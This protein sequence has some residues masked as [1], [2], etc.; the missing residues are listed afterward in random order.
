MDLLCDSTTDGPDTYDDFLHRP[1][2]MVIKHVLLR[3]SS[4]PAL[5]HIYGLN[6]LKSLRLFDS[7]TVKLNRLP[8][9]ITHLHLSRSAELQKYDNTAWPSDLTS[10]V[11]ECEPEHIP[12]LPR[13]LKTL[14]LRF[15]YAVRP[16]LNSN[17]LPP[18]LEDLI[19]NGYQKVRIRGKLPSAIR[20][21]GIYEI[22]DQKLD[23]LPASLEEFRMDTVNGFAG[24][25]QVFPKLLQKINVKWWSSANLRDLPSGLIGFQAETLQTLIEHEEYLLSLFPNG[26]KTLIVQKIAL[27]RIDDASLF[28]ANELPSLTK[29]AIGNI[30][31]PMASIK[32]LPRSLT[33]LKTD[34]EKIEENPTLLASLPPNLVHGP[35]NGEWANITNLGELMPPGS[36]RSLV[37][38][39]VAHHVRRLRQRLEAS[40]SLV[41]SPNNDK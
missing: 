7:P 41:K 4:A 38:T 20:R 13:R 15:H 35:V 37:G 29:L 9:S 33:S 28:H 21:F 36:W 32:H 39:P 5:E 16:T 22:A 14:S 34:L 40:Q 18:H 8:R 3:T 27:S 30:S 6:G 2:G 25:P 31:I 23:F 24:L 10:L 19:V 26:L 11:V 1:S 12:L 17:E